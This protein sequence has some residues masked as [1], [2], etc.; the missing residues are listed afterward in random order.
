MKATATGVTLVKRFVLQDGL[1]KQTGVGRNPGHW[2]ALPLFSVP[3][4]V[5]PLVEKILKADRRSWTTSHEG[6]TE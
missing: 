4:I 1:P 6:H 3:I 2:L 5:R